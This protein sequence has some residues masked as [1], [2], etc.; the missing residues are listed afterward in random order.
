MGAVVDQTGALVQVPKVRKVAVIRDGDG[1]ILDI[2]VDGAFGFPAYCTVPFDRY[3][4]AIRARD[5]VREDINA[6]RDP[7]IVVASVRAGP[8]EVPWRFFFFAV[9]L[10]IIVICIKSLAL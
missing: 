5:Q 9:S 7:D 6:G 3:E 4:D 10:A 1:A 8:D 2:T